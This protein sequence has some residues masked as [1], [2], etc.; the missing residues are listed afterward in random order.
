M[1]Q[2]AENDAVLSLHIYKTIYALQ[3]IVRIHTHLPPS[4]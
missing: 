2:R 3:L 1:A 4:N